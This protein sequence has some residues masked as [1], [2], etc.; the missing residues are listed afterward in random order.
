MASMFRILYLSSLIILYTACAGD[1]VLPS[2]LTCNDTTGT[3]TQY[4]TNIEGLVRTYCAYS[5]CHVGAP[6]VPGDYTTFSGMQQDL[7]NGRIETEVFSL[8][9]MPPANASGPKMLSS[10]DFDLFNC[11]IENGFPE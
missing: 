9:T 7:E 10:E 6:G 11:W 4:S 8:Q 3:P 2:D 5:G 1:T